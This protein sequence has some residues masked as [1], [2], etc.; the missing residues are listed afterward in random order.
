MD[1]D[2]NQCYDQLGNQDPFY[3]KLMSKI[4]DPLEKGRQGIGVCIDSSKI[5]IQSSRDFNFQKSTYYGP[6]NENH[7]TMTNITSF[8]GSIV[9]FGQVN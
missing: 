4:Q 2:K 1:E 3:V 6:K 7:I 9:H 5:P 8:D